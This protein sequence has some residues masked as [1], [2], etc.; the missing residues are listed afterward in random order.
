MPT[1]HGRQ[2]ARPAHA[3]RF[4]HGWRAFGTGLC[5]MLAA[6]CLVV[7]IA[8]RYARDNILNV[9][10]YMAIVGPLPSQPAVS[11]A[12]ATY[13]TDRLLDVTNA[14]QNIKDFLPP[15]LAPLASPLTDALKNRVNQTTQQFV[16]SDNF[17]AVWTAANRGAHTAVMRI[18][19]SEP[20]ERKAAAVG[21]VELGPL[22]ANIRERV[23]G[24][25]VLL[26]DQ[27]KDKIA[28]VRVNLQQSVEQL[29]RT[30]AAI[31]NGAQVLPYLGIAFLFLAL[32]L[33][34][35]RRRAFLGI[36]IMFTVV[37]AIMV[38]TFK[39]FSGAWLD[40]I[41]TPVYRTAAEVVYQAFYSDL[42]RRIMLAMW[43]GGVVILLALLAGPSTIAQEIRGALRLGAIKQTA[44][45]AWARAGRRFTAQYE[46]WID[47]AGGI[48]A[49]LVM[50]QLDKL[51]FTTG[52]VP[53]SLFVSFAA[54]VHLLARPAPVRLRGKKV[55][56]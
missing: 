22:L 34:Y 46:P 18:A 7:G 1:R 51:T 49:L 6:V 48:L 10:G 13:T 50:L 32:A 39:A 24:E 4:A 28:D 38:L 8:T 16:Q 31:K 20:R 27:Q 41:T 43:T 53:L 45:Y 56:A 26:T 44:P 21:S 9:D 3:Q 25:H 40:D 29:H 30:V 55:N 11:T 54:L 42:G 14:E 19:E 23:G 52:L 15:K 5:I 17:S 12:L 2:T 37:S 36:G 35:N 33:A 47:L